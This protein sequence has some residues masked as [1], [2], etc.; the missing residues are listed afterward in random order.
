MSRYDRPLTETF[1]RPLDRTP[2]LTVVVP[3]WERPAELTLAVSSIADQIDDELAGKVEIII[4]DNASGP[5]TRAVLQRLSETYPSVNY[6]IHAENH[7]GMYQVAIAPHRARGRWTWVFGDDDVLAPGGLKAVLDVLESE[8]PSFVTINRQVWDKSLSKCLTATRHNLPDMPFNT[9]IDL[10]KVFGFDQLSFFTSQVYDSELA[11]AFDV[12]PYLSSLCRYAQLAYYLEVFHGQSSYYLSKPVVLHRFD[13]S[14]LSVHSANF[15][16]LAT[17]LPELLQEVVERTGLD[18]DLLEQI[19]GHRLLLAPPTRKITF[20]DNTLENLWRCI[21]TG[22]SISEAEWAVLHQL[23]SKWRSDRSES[24]VEIHET[25]RK[26]ATALEHY[27][28]ILANHRAWTTPAGRAY[29]QEEVELIERSEA[30][31]Q[32]MRSN[33]NDAR[34][35]AFDVAA[36]FD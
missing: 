26:I 30:A 12:E 22:T 5:E 27:E 24:L 1:V 28:A 6:Y 15:H 33:I 34:K 36:S 7:G 16:S 8:Q 25:Y 31:I 3:T 17:S 14:A 4:S 13:T 32:F 11:R 18:S 19:S 23:S 9:F 29:S 10:L 2:V 20:V 35:M 21:A